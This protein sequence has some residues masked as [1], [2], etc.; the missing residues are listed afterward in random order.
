[1]LLAAGQGTPVTVNNA[2]TVTINASEAVQMNTP[3]LKVSGDIEA[4]GNVRD[5]VRSMAEDRAIYNGHNHGGGPAPTQ[6]Q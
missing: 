6:Q 2:T 1:M 5:Q 3:V 4:G